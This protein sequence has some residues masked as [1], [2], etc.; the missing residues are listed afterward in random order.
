M[1]TTVAA[2]RAAAAAAPRPALVW[3]PVGS[4]RV[5]WTFE[6]LLGDAARLGEVLAARIP[7][8]RALGLQ[9]Q[10]S[11]AWLVAQHAAALAGIELVA[12][13]PSL[14]PEPT[15]AIARRTNCL[16]VIRE[17]DLIE[18]REVVPEPLPLPDIDGEH[19]GA[20]VVI[21]ADPADGL[22]DLREHCLRR[23]P[24]AAV[25]DCIDIVAEIPRTGLGKPRRG[26]VRAR[27]QRRLHP[28]T[29][30]T[31][32]QHPVTTTPE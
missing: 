16:T 15:E 2:L 8:G 9:A 18:L 21:R 5:R 10:P 29:T 7:A 32:G 24:H 6:Q 3:A 30:D 31:A 28:P 14:P 4:P 13:P 12:I 27:M 19:V 22:P 26:E 25:P 17:R 1:L 20:E 23:L 11:G